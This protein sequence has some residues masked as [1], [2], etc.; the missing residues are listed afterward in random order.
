[1]INFSC[2]LECRSASISNFH[3]IHQKMHL[4]PNQ[5]AFLESKWAY[6]LKYMSCVQH[7]GSEED[8]KKQH[9]YTQNIHLGPEQF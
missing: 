8:F 5:C 9:T 7:A 4:K 1:M 6:G 3:L 2:L